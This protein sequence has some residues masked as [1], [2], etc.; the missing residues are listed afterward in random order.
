METGDGVNALVRGPALEAPAA[1]GG[2]DDG[3]GD[4]ARR[5]AALDALLSYAVNAEAVGRSVAARYGSVLGVRFTDA[6][7]EVLYGRPGALA[8]VASLGLTPTAATAAAAG[9]RVDKYGAGGGGDGRPRGRVALPLADAEAA[10]ARYLARCAA[11]GVPVPPAMV[12]LRRVDGF[13]YPP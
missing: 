6:R 5:A 12:Q 13:A 9:V 10:T 1:G 3:G 2:G 7:S 8:L 4:G 11:Q